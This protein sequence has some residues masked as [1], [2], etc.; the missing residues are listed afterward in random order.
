MT[1]SVIY[2]ALALYLLS[3]LFYLLYLISDRKTIESA[4]HFFLL[5]GFLVHL[6]LTVFRYIQAGY[7]PITN[8]H[9]SLSFLS[10]SVA[11]FFLLIKRSYRISI[12][13]SVI[14]PV[15]SV[16]LISAMTFPTE[17][18]PLP[19]VLKSYWLPV[20]TVFSFA[21]NAIFLI[22]FFV[23]I[24][25]LL[26]ERGIKKKKF[27]PISLRFPSLETLDSVNYRC[28]SY[29]FPFLTIGIITG[30]IWAGMAWGSYWNW[31]PKETWSL[32]T[33][34]VY[35][36]L[37]HN[38]LA[39]GWRGRRTAYMMIVGFISIVFTFLGVAFFMGGRHS[40]L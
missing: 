18:R 31:D 2:S 27:L 5:G 26:V 3:T 30:S 17:I 6:A 16:I 13:G 19:V 1:D 40:Y 36:I 39:I 10:L 20:H 14:V 4:G 37:I 35:A 22:S 38:R 24:L 32:I 9:E 25:Y 23:S 8:I 29:G 12:L 7:T 15:L 33:W 11:G 28:M 21:G 34:I